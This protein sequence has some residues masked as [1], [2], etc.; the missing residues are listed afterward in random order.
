MVEQQYRKLEVASSNLAGGSR[1]LSVKFSKSPKIK[2]LN[3]DHLKSK[4]K[5]LRSHKAFSS[6][7]FLRLTY[8]GL[9][10]NLI[11]WLILLLVARPTSG[12]VP[13]RYTLS[14]GVVQLGQWYSLYMFPAIGLL[15]FLS[16]LILA[17]LIY[18]KEKLVGLILVGF[19]VF[20]QI[21]ILIYEILLILIILG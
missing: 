12:L 1:E 4:F 2:T 13:L 18:R 9:F 5:E 20:A 3:L 17:L 19:P 7:I 11:L 15:V 14:L 21:L 10:L 16:N 8:L 6:K